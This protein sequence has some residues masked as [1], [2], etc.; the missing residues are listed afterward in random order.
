MEENKELQEIEINL[1]AVAEG[2]IDESF[3][4]TF[5]WEIRPRFATLLM[6][7]GEKRNISTATESL[8]STTLRPTR[9][10]SLW[11]PQ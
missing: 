5:G 1:N 6:F 10:S 4:R 9:A 8:V 7:S 2:K 3:L 11:T